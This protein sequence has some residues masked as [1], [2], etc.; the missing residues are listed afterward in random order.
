M[1][2]RNP[3]RRRYRRWAGFESE[4]PYTFRWLLRNWLKDIRWEMVDDL[5]WSREA[6]NFRRG[7]AQTFFFGNR[8]LRVKYIPDIL[9]VPVPPRDEEAIAESIRWSLE[10]RRAYQEQAHA[11]FVQ[12]DCRDPRHQLLVNFNYEPDYHEVAFS[13]WQDISWMPWWRR[14]WEVF[15]AMRGEPRMVAGHGEVAPHEA[16]V[17]YRNLGRYLNRLV[18]LGL[19]RPDDLTVPKD[20]CQPPTDVV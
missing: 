6:G 9:K 10:H 1:K 14:V 11:L 13:M 5:P 15:R 4:R 18:E 19:L 20:S 2:L 16:A 17:L 7:H 12:C 8:A 3:L